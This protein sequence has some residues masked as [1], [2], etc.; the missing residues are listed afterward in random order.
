VGSKLNEA[1]CASRQ[2]WTANVAFGSKAD[3]ASIERDVR[4]TPK[5]GHCRATVGCPL[6]AKSGLMHRSDKTLFDHLVGSAE[7][8]QRYVDA[9]CVGDLWIDDKLSVSR[10]LQN[11]NCRFPLQMLISL[12]GAAR[13]A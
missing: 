4:F 5:S 9:E 6:C 11:R 10:E 12:A 2:K 3:I 13:K 8:R 7:Q 1:C